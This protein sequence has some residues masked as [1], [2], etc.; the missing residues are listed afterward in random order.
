M[1]FQED[2]GNY[3][4]QSLCPAIFEAPVKF[5]LNPEKL[6]SNLPNIIL[7]EEEAKKLRNLYE[8]KN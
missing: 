6:K 5:T 3:L 1:K 2:F 4:P 8:N 7:S